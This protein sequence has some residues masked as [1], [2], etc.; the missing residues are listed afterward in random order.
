M[1]RWRALDLDDSPLAWVVL[2]WTAMGILVVAFLPVA[3]I[4]VGLLW[5]MR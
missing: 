5:L 4:V 1:R 2:L 3:L